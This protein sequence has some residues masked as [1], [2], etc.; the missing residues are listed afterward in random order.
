MVVQ[1]Y[2]DKNHPTFP[3]IFSNK[4]THVIVLVIT[5][6]ST[7]LHTKWRDSIFR[8]C[9]LVQ[10]SAEYEFSNTLENIVSSFKIFA[11]LVYN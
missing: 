7:N 6:N 3:F 8:D 10:D 9:V 4:Q 1:K 5:K 11:Y 2:K